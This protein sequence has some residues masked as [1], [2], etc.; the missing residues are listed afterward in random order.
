MD[1]DCVGR[2]DGLPRVFFALVLL[3]LFV[4]VGPPLQAEQ[5][6][7]LWFYLRHWLAGVLI[8]P[9]YILAL[10]GLGW[11]LARIAGSSR[12]NDVRDSHS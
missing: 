4:S 1:E 8:F 11:F 7:M 12:K 6:G 2:L 5:Q 9:V 10:S 3:Y